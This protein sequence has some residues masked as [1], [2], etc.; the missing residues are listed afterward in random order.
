MA[1]PHERALTSFLVEQQG[2]LYRMA[3]SYL[4]NSDDALD[5]VQTT[6]CKAL[7][8]C[9]DLRNP[10]AVRTWVTRILIR[11]CT[12]M[13]AQRQK[14]IFLPGE[15]LDPGSYE[16]PPLPDG[17]LA[18]KV[19]ALPVNTRTVIKLRFY[20]DMTLKD[21]SAVTGWNLNT[22]KSRLYAGLKALKVSMEGVEDP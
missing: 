17:T 13:L 15:E 10:A 11:V 7:E 18:Q 9:G 12:D 1:S 6:A 19:E 3:F 4:K 21:I 22:V 16:D 8:H 20:G 5:A 14:L 2:Y